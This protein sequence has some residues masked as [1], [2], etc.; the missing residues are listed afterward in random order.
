MLFLFFACM[1]HMKEIQQ[2]HL[3]LKEEQKAILQRLEQLEADLQ[4]G[5]DERAYL[6]DSVRFVELS[7]N[8]EKRI[9]TVPKEKYEQLSE[10]PVSS[11][12]LVTSWY[13][14]NKKIEGIDLK[15]IPEDS[16]LVGLG[17]QDGDR[18]LFVNGHALRSN[19]Q[20]M[21]IYQS[22][23][24]SRSCQVLLQRDKK[25]LLLDLQEE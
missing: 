2:D 16:F 15:R 17:V 7:R 14:N 19:E 3:R 12:M 10:P 23:L 11:D 18:I 5:N 13:E 22:V 24:E 9:I 1:G 21:K 8:A 4:K 6:Q 20:G 25:L